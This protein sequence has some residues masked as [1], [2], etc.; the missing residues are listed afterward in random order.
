MLR[1][2]SQ[3]RIWTFSG[4]YYLC[5]SA[6]NYLSHEET[7]AAT[8][9]FFFSNQEYCLRKVRFSDLLSLRDVYD[10]TC[11]G[12]NHFQAEFIL[13]GTITPD[14]IN[15][16]WYFLICSIQ[17]G[18]AHLAVNEL[19]GSNTQKTFT[20]RLCNALDSSCLAQS[21]EYSRCSIHICWEDEWQTSS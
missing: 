14:D 16:F 9:F 7:K 4:R 21:R 15:P 18:G 11:S 12:Y 8:D 1:D 20:T 10:V 3:D 6:Q 5:K 17:S 13:L 19:K 2:V